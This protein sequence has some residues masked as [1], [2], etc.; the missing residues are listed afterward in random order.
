MKGSVRKKLWSGFIVILLFMLIIGST[1]IVAISNIHKDYKVLLDERV[2]KVNVAQELISAQKDSFAAL[3]G[4]V[5]H[6]SL[7]FI[8]IRDEAIKHSEQVMEEI[9]VVFT[10]KKD[11]KLLTEIETLQNDYNDKILDMRGSAVKIRESALEASGL[12]NRL[13]SYADELK[14][15]QQIEM[16]KT[17]SNIDKLVTFT[18]VLMAGLIV[19]GLIFSAL[20]A[21]V[22][23]RGIARPVHKMTTAIEQIAAGDLTAEHVSIK[24]RDEIGMMASSFNK[25]TDDLKELLARIRFSSRQLALQAEQLSASSEESLASSEMVASAAEANLLGSEQQTIIVNTT[26][27]SMKELQMGMMQISTSN[28]EMLES[29]KTVSELVHKGSS[30]VTEVSDQMNTIHTTIAQSSAIIKQMA[31]QATKIQRVTTIITEISE[32]TN[33]LALNA[34]IEAARAGEHGK[35]F[36]VVAEEVRRL[37]EQSKSS[38]SEIET[39][40]NTIQ[41]D[42]EKA[43]ISIDEGNTSVSFGLSSTENSLRVFEDIEKAVGE[44]NVKVGTVSVAIAQIQSVTETVSNGSDEIKQL[45]EAASLTAQE[46]SAATEEQHAV[47]E[48][49]SSSS[50]ALADVAEVLQSEV[51]RFKI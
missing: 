26:V 23:S 30:I 7:E 13:M 22:L 51:N 4:Y 29:S 1:A 3:N 16:D 37:A 44:V 31:E 6:K 36:A 19:L 5:V 18:N 43:V 21:T 27:D 46:T 35:G 34:A 10:E 39:M 45:A 24:N 49:M 48:E 15:S 33:L 41:I 42:T 50:Q 12:N 2:Y 17:R 9:K 11:L 47:N 20:I 28:E 40:M 8:Q 32:Q 38:A 25:M 14:A